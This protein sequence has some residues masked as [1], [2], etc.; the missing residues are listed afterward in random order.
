MNEEKEKY[1]NPFTD[2]GF[3][4]LF[5]EEPNK[6]LLIDFLNELLK[7]ESKIKNLTYGKLEKLGDIVEER[8]AV[9]DL[10]CENEYGEKFI[11]EIQKAKQDFFKDR[12][13]FYSTFPIRE[14]AQKGSTWNFELKA[15]YSIGILDFRFDDQDKDKTIVNEVKLMDT[16]KKTVFY[17][18]LTYIYIQMPN[19]TK[20]EKELTTHFDKWLYVLK[21][22]HKFQNHPEILREKIFEKLFKIA[23]ISN[24]TR[25][26]YEEYERSL[27]SYRDMQNTMDYKY[28]KG[29]KVGEKTGLIK[30]EKIGRKEEKIET[31]KKSIKLGID[32]DTISK[33]TG[34]TKEEI[35]KYCK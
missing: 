1:I 35:E 25:E 8:K 2:F 9:F 19:F 20:T 23:E 29:E 6:D 7:N 21:N 5:G 13:I 31:V 27:K 10:Y 14:Q 15:V 12:T 26:E 17:D 11:V 3:K 33:I 18:K 22:L 4:K 34:L 30:G 16:E 24:F 32:S 28:R